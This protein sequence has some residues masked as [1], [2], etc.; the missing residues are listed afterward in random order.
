MAPPLGASAVDFAAGQ[1][2]ANNAVV[3]LRGGGAVGVANVSS[4]TVDVVVDVNGY[5]K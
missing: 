1:T 2:R 3:S 4:G 5:F